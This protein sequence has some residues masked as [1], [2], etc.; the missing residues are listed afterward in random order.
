MKNSIVFFAAVIGLFISIFG[1]SQSAT[2]EDLVQF[3]GI[4]LSADSLNPVSFT[5]IIIADSSAKK[6]EFLK[7]TASDYYGFFSFIAKKNDTI[8]FSA[9]GYKPATFVIP[10]TIVD[11]RYSLIQLMAADTILLSESVIYPWPSKEDFKDVFVNLD[12]PDDDITVAKKNIELAKLK[13]AARMYA[14]EGSLNYRQYINSTTSKLYYAG[15][16]PP[17]NL[18]N[19]FAWAQFIKAWKEGKFKTDKKLKK[20]IK[21]QLEVD[22][23]RWDYDEW[24]EKE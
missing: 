9:V 13:E 7:G 16:I 20:E 4:V 10:D 6:G 12:I 23:Q 22:K 3:S 24:E 2:D 15:Q 1:Y 14:R 19:P 8:Y 18:L 17:N 21:R 5:T 11:R